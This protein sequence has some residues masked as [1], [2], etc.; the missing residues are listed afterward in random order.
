M[1]KRFAYTIM[2]Q[3]D[4]FVCVTISII[5]AT[6]FVPSVLCIQPVSSTE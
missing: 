1:I 4:A 5:N 6:I 2:M 3:P